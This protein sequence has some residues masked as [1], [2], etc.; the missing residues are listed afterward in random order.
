M[1]R[2]AGRQ[3]G[4]GHR[5]L[6]TGSSRRAVRG[7]AGERWLAG[8]LAGRALARLRIHKSG[9]CGWSARWQS[10]ALVGRLQPS[11]RPHSAAAARRRPPQ[12]LAPPPSPAGKG[13]KL[14]A[15][16]HA[17]QLAAHAPRTCKVK[18]QLKI[19]QTYLTNPL[20]L[21]GRKFH[22]RLWVLVTGGALLPLPPA[23]L[24]AWRWRAAATAR[25]GPALHARRRA[26]AHA[27][28]QRHPGCLPAPA[29]RKPLRA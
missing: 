4:P 15:T 21:D 11:A 6:A 1:A 12:P 16:A 19:A 18:Q 22:L 20:L 13:L 9:C 3:P 17:L 8:W 10:L 28:S 24:A 27:R 2:L 5:A 26:P 7:W 23:A 14:A 29:G 25:R